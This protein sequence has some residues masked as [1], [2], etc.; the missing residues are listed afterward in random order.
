M[1]SPVSAASSSAC[2]APVPLIES[3]A[4]R[5]SRSA[6]C[7]GVTRA[8][9]SP[10]CL[11]ARPARSCVIQFAAPSGSAP[12]ATVASN[13]ADDAR[14]PTRTRAT[15]GFRP[16]SA[17]SARAEPSRQLGQ[18]HP[19]LLD[20]PRPRARSPG[21][22]A[23]GSTGS[24]TPPPSSASTRSRRRPRSSGGSPARSLAGLERLRLARDLVVERPLERAGSS[25]CS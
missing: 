22:R 14:S 12:S 10:P 16:W 19:Q 24:R 23:P 17:T 20:P 25:S 3:S 5:S 4:S 8:A 1:A 9:A 13:I 2:L 18:R 11:F 6:R 7:C 21:C 15:S